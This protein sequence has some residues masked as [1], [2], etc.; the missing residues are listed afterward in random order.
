LFLCIDTKGLIKESIRRNRR[1][2]KRK[3]SESFDYSLYVPPQRLDE[4]DSD[5]DDDNKAATFY[6]TNDNNSW[7]TFGNSSV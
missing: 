4:S 5:S 7:N 6:N 1:K 3:R 2:S